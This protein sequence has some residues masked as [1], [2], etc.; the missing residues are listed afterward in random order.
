VAFGSYGWGKKGGPHAVQTYLEDMKCD[1]LL[2]EPLQC[3][4]VPTEKN[5]EECRELGRQMGKKAL[6]FK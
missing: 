5:L 4:Y 3:Q 6:S 2:E 1:L